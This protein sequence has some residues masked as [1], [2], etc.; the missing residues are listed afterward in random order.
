MSI[1]W[2]FLQG[3]L[4]GLKILKW[5]PGWAGRWPAAVGHLTWAPRKS[6]EVICGQ[7][8]GMV[9]ITSQGLC[10]WNPGWAMTRSLFPPQTQSHANIQIVFSFNSSSW[11][12]EWVDRI[13]FKKP[14]TTFG[15]KYLFLVY[16]RHLLSGTKMSCSQTNK[17]GART[18]T[19]FIEILGNPEGEREVTLL[20]FSLPPP[21]PWHSNLKALDHCMS[22]A[23]GV[24]SVSPLLVSVVISAHLNCTHTYSSISNTVLVRKSL[25]PQEN[26]AFHPC[27]PIDSTFFWPL[28]QHSTHPLMTHLPCVQGGGVL[29]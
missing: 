9:F 11:W 22:S 24:L 15:T 25:I 6:R 1:S 23:S 21:C 5:M 28:L 7:P 26:Q 3:L 13:Q 2:S 20:G 4:W 17:A 27:S 16:K 12:F 10:R 14:L 8:R 19:F 29:L 18:P